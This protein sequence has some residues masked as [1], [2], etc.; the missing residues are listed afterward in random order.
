[1]GVYFS[2]Y[3]GEDYIQ[4][5]LLGS[6]VAVLIGFINSER[7]GH[8]PSSLDFLATHVKE[9]DKDSDEDLG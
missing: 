6:L 8:V 1:M 7:E 9:T 4:E 3:V 5:V 2:L